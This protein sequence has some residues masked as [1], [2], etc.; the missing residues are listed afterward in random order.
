M[1]WVVRN[2]KKIPLFFPNHEATKKIVSVG[3]TL[4]KDLLQICA[5][6][7]FR[8]VDTICLE[9]AL[10]VAV[11]RGSPVF[12]GR[13]FPPQVNISASSFPPGVSCSAATSGD[14]PHFNFSLHVWKIKANQNPPPAPTTSPSP[15]AADQFWGQKR[16]V[17]GNAVNLQTSVQRGERAYLSPNTLV[18]KKVFL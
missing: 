4:W 9:K 6:S 8:P 12:S 11:E 13:R 1:V 14:F 16:G 7:S 17:N 10:L 18:K 3:N 2:C 15:P 5:G